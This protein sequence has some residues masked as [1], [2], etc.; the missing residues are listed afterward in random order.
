VEDNCDAVGST[1]RGKLTGTFGDFSTTSFYPAHH[2]TMGEGGC[3]TTDNLSYARLIESLRDWGRDCWCEPGMNDT[4]HKRFSQQFAG[5]PHGYDH[6]YTFSHI[7]YNL[8]TTDLQAALGLSQLRR[9]A[10][11]GEARRRNWQHLRVALDGVPGLLLPEATHDS[12]PSWFGFI[13]TVRD[14]APFERAELV[15]HLES[16]M[17]GTRMLFAGNLTRQPAYRDVEY[18]VVGELT[19]SDTVMTRTFWVG[20]YPSL[21]TEMLDYVAETIREFAT[22]RGGGLAL[23][24]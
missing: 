11:F 8:K 17:I 6:K 7:G 16:R 20:V 12:D 21:T 18:R 1:Y 15:R 10:D 9:L 5:L 24:Q 3:V 2:L 13:L 19:N 23:A 4:C 22:R 14:D